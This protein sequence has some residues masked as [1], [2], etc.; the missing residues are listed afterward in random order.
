MG[1]VRK[2]PARSGV[3]S[4]LKPTD[5]RKIVWPEWMYDIPRDEDATLDRARYEA[6]EK[7]KLGAG[8][9]WVCRSRY[10]NSGVI[11]YRFFT[12]TMDTI[13]MLGG[14]TSQEVIEIHDANGI[15]K[16]GERDG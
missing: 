7:L 5:I 4:L 10:K 16:P 9:V 12:L 15:H 11:G 6:Q 2:Q 3:Q 13:A 14:R 8:V 1:S